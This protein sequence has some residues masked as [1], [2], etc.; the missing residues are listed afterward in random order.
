MACSDAG[1]SAACFLK[2][3]QP[4]PHSQAVSSLRCQKHLNNYLLVRKQNHEVT[5]R[6]I[7]FSILITSIFF[8]LAIFYIV[9]FQNNSSILKYWNQPTNINYGKYPYRLSVLEV[10]PSLEF[11]KITNKQDEYL[12]VI[13]KGNTKPELHFMFGHNKPYGFGESNK[14]NSNWKSINVKAYLEKC[15]VVWNN[16]GV[17]FIEPSGH[18]LFFP[19]TVFIQE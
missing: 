8:L 2:Q 16:E 15:E 6:N 13:S 19:K 12:M 9:N 4:A 11:F 1:D 18:T 5:L 7:I 3:R 17:I 10:K 14:Y